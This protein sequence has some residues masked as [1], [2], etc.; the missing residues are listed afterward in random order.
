MKCIGQIQLN[1]GVSQIVY[2]QQ[3]GTVK[4]FCL[5]GKTRSQK[6]SRNNEFGDNASHMQS[7]FRHMHSRRH[8]Q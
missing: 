6:E 5:I 7:D 1:T 8:L 4:G 3:W 2:E